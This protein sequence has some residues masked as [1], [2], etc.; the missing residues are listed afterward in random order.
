[1]SPED[2]ERDARRAQGA[3]S[4]VAAGIAHGFASRVT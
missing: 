2:L 1:V 4:Q 3:V